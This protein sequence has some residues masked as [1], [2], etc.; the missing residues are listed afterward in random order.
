MRGRSTKA[1]L[2]GGFCVSEIVVSLSSQPP[3]LMLLVGAIRSHKY[4]HGLLPGQ[5][6]QVVQVLYPEEDAHFGCPALASSGCLPRGDSRLYGVFNCWTWPR[7]ALAS[8]QIRNPVT[9]CPTPALNEMPESGLPDVLLG[10]VADDG[11]CLEARVAR[12]EVTPED[13]V[14]SFYVECPVILVVLQEYKR[15]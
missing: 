2:Q 5:Y 8:S 12:Y 7:D 13:C 11:A 1:V 4:H 3:S 14:D 9:C 6:H 15:R 10:C